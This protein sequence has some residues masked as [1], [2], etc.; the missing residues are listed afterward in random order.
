MVDVIAEEHESQRLALS[1]VLEGLRSELEDAWR[2]SEGRPVRFR[3]SDVTLTVE[4][5]FSKD[6]DAS[7]RIRWWIVEAG[8]G[9]RSGKQRSQT[10][11]LKLTPGLYADD[12]APPQ[13]LDVGDEQA[14]PGG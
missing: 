11:V 2:T 5:V 12:G 6:K 4:T 1:A 10:L 8:G 3:A 14:S 7:G 13:P 9:A